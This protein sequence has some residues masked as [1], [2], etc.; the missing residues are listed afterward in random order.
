MPEQKIQM[1]PL[2]RIR[3][4]LDAEGIGRMKFQ[5]L[6]VRVIWNDDSPDM[7]PEYPASFQMTPDIVP[8][9]VE[10]TYT[11][12]VWIWEGV[13][14]NFKEVVLFHE[15]TEGWAANK[16]M[17]PDAAHELAVRAHL[18]YAKSFLSEENFATFKEWQDKL[19]W[20]R[21]GRQ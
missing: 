21:E 16:G 5:G 4:E 15:L 7:G 17:D 18:A 1:P 12:S 2:E 6:N 13:P 11:L 9:G 3:M 19:P 20:Y 14:A 8:N 10:P